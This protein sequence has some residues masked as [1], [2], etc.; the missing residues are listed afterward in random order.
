MIIVDYMRYRIMLYLL[1][2][3][4]LRSYLPGGRRS[5]ILSARNVARMSAYEVRVVFFGLFVS[6]FGRMVTSGE[7]HQMS[8]IR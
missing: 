7:A 3:L 6:L 4:Y 5:A 2:L 1:V 8:T